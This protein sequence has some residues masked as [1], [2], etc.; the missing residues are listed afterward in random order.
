[1]LAAVARLA[2][3]E[4]KNRL[5]VLRDVGAEWRGACFSCTALPPAVVV[6]GPALPLRGALG[7]SSSGTPPWCAVLRVSAVQPCRP[8]LVGAGEELSGEEVLNVDVHV[9]TCGRFADSE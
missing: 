6:S 8:R 7:V 3:E 2:L 1:M 4:R 9:R 5:E